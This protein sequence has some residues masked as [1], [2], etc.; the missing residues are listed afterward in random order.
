MP[1]TIDL[2]DKP[3]AVQGIGAVGYS[4]VEFRRAAVACARQEG[5]VAPGDFKVT[6]GAGLT[7]G[8][9]A[10]E[11]AVQGDSVAQQGLYYQR[12]SAAAAGLSLVNPPDVTNPRI[13]QIVLEIK[14]DAHDAG[15]L[16]VGRIRVVQGTATAGATL[17]NRT[18]AAA[19][20]NTCVRLADLLVPAAFAGP[21]VAAT[22]LMDRRPWARGA[23]ARKYATGTFSTGSGAFSDID[24]TNLKP[25]LEITAGNVVEFTVS[26][27]VDST[28][29]Q[30]FRLT[31]DGGAF[32]TFL[33]TNATLLGN[34]AATSNGYHT[35]WQE[36]AVPAGGSHTFA[37]QYAGFNSATNALSYVHVL[38]A[39]LLPAADNT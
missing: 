31:M 26:M 19:L 7:L 2:A 11:A 39:E 4:A 28:V 32:E 20:P 30:G 6:P 10:G 13:D 9:A 16:N 5:V 24:A 21:F 15:G 1:S 12:A 38:V 33:P 23:F 34:S 8:V 29:G 17:A 14:D 18:G 25:R 22:H 36:T 35:T 3:V 37:P 27:R